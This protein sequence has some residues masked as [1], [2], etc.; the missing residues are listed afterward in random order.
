MATTPAVLI[1]VEE[2][3]RTVYRPDRDYIDGE[4]LE[5]N[6]GE[7]PHG[8]LQTFFAFFFRTREDEW[9]VQSFTETRL[10]VQTTRYRIPD[11]MLVSIPNDNDRIVR[12]PPLLCIEIL[13]SEDRMRKVQE[14][15]DDYAA[16]GVP[17]TWVVDPWRGLAYAARPDGKLHPVEDRLTVATTSIAIT[18]PE[19][20]A[21]LD[22]LEKRA[23]ARPAALPKPIA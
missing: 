7:T 20:F 16:M 4:V 23:A 2:Y 18:V 9:N 1:P 3:L 11:L 19:I 21:E 10:Q 8:C 6:M 12:T 13:S 5:R 17:A 14:R 22:R 15:A